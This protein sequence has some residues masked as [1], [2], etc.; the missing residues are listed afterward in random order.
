MSWKAWSCYYVGGM[1]M[2]FSGTHHNAW[3]TSWC[4]SLIG[5]IGISLFGLVGFKSERQEN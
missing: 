3:Y 2:Y 5:W 4:L 1:G